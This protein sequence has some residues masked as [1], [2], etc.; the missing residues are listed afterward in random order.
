[1]Y[2]DV[3][4][5]WF[6]AKGLYDWY[7]DLDTEILDGFEFPTKD[8]VYFSGRE[9]FLDIWMLGQINKQDFFV[10]LMAYYDQLPDTAKKLGWIFG[11]TDPRKKEITL[12]DRG[13][14][15]HCITGRRNLRLTHAEG[16]SV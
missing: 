5:F 12:T 9:G 7:F 15:H 1:L 14:D 10:D 2:A 16:V 4:R 3:A 8:G 11:F 6:L 13:V